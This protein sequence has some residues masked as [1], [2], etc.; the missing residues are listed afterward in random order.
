[1]IA[2]SLRTRALRELRNF[3]ILAL[4]LW[5]C[6]AALVFLGDAMMRFQGSSF[7]PWGFAA[8]KA[9]IIAKFVMLGEMLHLNK[10]RARERLWVSILRR[11]LLLLG[12][13][14]VLTFLEEVAVSLI[15]G[16]ALSDSIARAAAKDALQLTAKVVVMLLILL[17]YVGLSALGEAIGEDKLMHL[18]V[19]PAEADLPADQKP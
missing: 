9:V 11:A 16:Q 10:R 14:V 19:A 17:P 6:F 8:I 5:V 18:L 7:L 2:D 13:L 4:Y 12:L 3:G 15:H 1:M